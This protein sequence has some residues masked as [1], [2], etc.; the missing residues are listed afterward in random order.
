MDQNSVLSCSPNEEALIVRHTLLSNAGMNVTSVMT[1]TEARFEIEMGRCGSLLICH[2]LSSPQLD[3]ITT[4]FRRYCPKGRI[5][6]VTGGTI[7]DH[8]PEAVDIYVPE[9]SGPLQILNA[10]QEFQSKRAAMAS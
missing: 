9:S 5:V 10:L 6:F 1:L 7:P 4:L 8:V 2:R 3:D